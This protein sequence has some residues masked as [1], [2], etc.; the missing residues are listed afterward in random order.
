MHRNT[1]F[2]T[3]SVCIGALLAKIKAEKEVLLP[4]LLGAFLLWDSLPSLLKIG[5][6]LRK[7][8]K[9]YD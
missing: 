2:A 7:V 5:L 4:P 9:F 6:K 3:A 1:G 8:I